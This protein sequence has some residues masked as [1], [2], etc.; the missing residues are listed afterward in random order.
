MF[1]SVVERF[2]KCKTGHGHNGKPM[3]CGE[4]HENFE[5]NKVE[6]NKKQETNMFLIVLVVY[7][8]ILFVLAPWLWNNILCRLVPV[9]KKSEWYDMFLLALLLSILLPARM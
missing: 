9:L 2:T 4:N 6:L 1:W 7:I 8:L 3:G 5:N